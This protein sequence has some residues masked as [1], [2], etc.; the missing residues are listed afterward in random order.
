MNNPAQNPAE[1]VAENESG[2]LAGTLV[3]TS[4]GALE[5]EGDV[6]SAVDGHVDPVSH[7][8]SRPDP[9]PP[10]PEPLPVDYAQ[11]HALACRVSS[12]ACAKARA[13]EE[14]EA[15]RM[16]ACMR[17]ESEH[18]L[19]VIVQGLP[20]AVMDAARQGLREAVVAQ[21]EGCTKFGTFCYLFLIKGPHNDLTAWQEMKRAGCVPLLTRLRD[22]LQPAGFRVWHSWNRA[23][24]DNTLCVA[25]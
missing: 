10:Q 6:G 19:S 24:N 14:E 5:A 3:G 23:T 8:E 22:L 13:D 1:S 12:E 15:A 16:A 18:L 20:S 11:L 4:V 7:A 2:V 9:V 17:E 25:W 21:F